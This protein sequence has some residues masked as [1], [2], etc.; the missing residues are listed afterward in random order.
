[1]IG[2]PIEST[3]I[4]RT[5]DDERRKNLEFEFNPWQIELVLML[6]QNPLK[7]EVPSR[8]LVVEDTGNTSR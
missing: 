5:C 8:Y 2:L 6:K 3:Q 7:V 1:M 4:C